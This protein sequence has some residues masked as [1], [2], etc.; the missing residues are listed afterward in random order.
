MAI[1]GIAFLI[2]QNWETVG[3]FLIGLWNQIKTALLE[4][5]TQIQ[6]AV[7]TLMVSFVRLRKL[8]QML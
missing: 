5:W 7:T 4:A 6:P 3:P 8:Y 1:A 2:Y